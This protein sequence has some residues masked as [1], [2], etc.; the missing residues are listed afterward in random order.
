MWNINLNRHNW[1]ETVWLLIKLLRLI[2]ELSLLKLGW[3]HLRV[4]IAILMLKT[5]LWNHILM[6]WVCQ[7]LRGSILRVDEL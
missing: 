2:V 5:G 7:A 6:L 1:L 3:I 4:A